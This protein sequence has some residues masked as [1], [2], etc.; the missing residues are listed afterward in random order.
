VEFSV[1]NLGAVRHIA[2][3][4]LDVAFAGLQQAVDPYRDPGI[5]TDGIVTGISLVLQVP[6]FTPDVVD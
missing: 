3:Q 6:L 1:S 2:D 4:F 5:F